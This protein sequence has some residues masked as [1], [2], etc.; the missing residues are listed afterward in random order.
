MKRFRIR[1]NWYGELKEYW[2]HADSEAQARAFVVKKFAEDI[3]REPFSV[4]A[5][6]NGSKDNMTIEEA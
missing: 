1:L 2:T 6:F 4:L 3:G 5:Y